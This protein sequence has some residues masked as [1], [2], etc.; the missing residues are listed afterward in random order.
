MIKKYLYNLVSYFVNLILPLLYGSY[1]YKTLGPE[2]NGKIAYINVIIFYVSFFVTFS[3]QSI[4]IRELSKLRNDHDLFKQEA[5]NFFSIIF[6]NSFFSFLIYVLI[7]IFILDLNNFLIYFI[8]GIS[9]V[10][11]GL[12]TEYI[13]ISNENFKLIAVR[14]LILK[15]IYFVTFF[16]FIK[17][18]N[19]FPLYLIIL[20][21]SIFIT[22][23]FFIYKLDFVIKINYNIELLKIYWKR[24]KNFHYMNIGMMLYNKTPSFILINLVSYSNIGIF[25]FAEKFLV[26]AIGF[27]NILVGTFQP[28]MILSKAIDIETYKK[29]YFYYFL[30]NSFILGLIT[31]IFFLSSY[32]IVTYLGGTQYLNSLILLKIGS[33]LIFISG[34]SNFITTLNLL[35]YNKEDILLK[36]S[37]KSFLI[38]LPIIITCVLKFGVIGALI[39]WISSELIM[40]LFVFYQSY[41]EN[42]NIKLIYTQIYIL[43][44]L[45]FIFLITEIASLKLTIFNYLIASLVYAILYLLYIYIINIKLKLGLVS[46]KIIKWKI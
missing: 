41:K 21:I 9:I 20:S 38:S 27:S 2:I 34:S 35:V 45:L 10:A 39:G 18:K 29:N 7:C 19:D 33:I 44:F 15:I 46:K 40:C 6:L 43:L 8:I 37:L 3:L 30:L 42:H 17:N 11:N 14:S 22:N 26:T 36:L 32:V 24:V 28:K 25:S 1:I 4:A 5:N 16:T 12:T 13:Y 31:I 23:L